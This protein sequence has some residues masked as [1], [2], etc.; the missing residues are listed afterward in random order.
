MPAGSRYERT[1]VGMRALYGTGRTAAR[2][3]PRWRRCLGGRRLAALAALAAIAVLGGCALDGGG[4]VGHERWNEGSAPR[5]QLRTAS[6]RPAESIPLPETPSLQDYLAYAALNNPGLEAAFE[7]WKAALERI[8]QVKALPD[9]RFTYRYYLRS[10]ETRD[11]PQEQGFGL[12]QAFPW[13]GKLKLKG[14]AAWEAAEAARMRYE[15]QRLRLFYRVKDAYY[16]YYYLGRAIAVVKEQRDFLKYLEEVLR[17]RYRA[18]AARHADVI[19]AQV[20]L[21]KL[22]DRH[23]TLMDLQEPMLARLNAALNRPADAQLPWPTEVVEPAL[24]ATDEEIMAWLQVASPELLE[25]QHE[26]AREEYG[27]QLARKDYYPDVTLGLDYV[28]TGSAVMET[29]DSGKDPVMAMVSL[30]LPIWSQ[31]RHAGV[32]EAESR[33]RAAAHMLQERANTLSAQVK[34]VLYRFRDAERKID[35]YRDTLLPKARQSVN[36]SETALRAATATFLDVMDAVRILLEFELSHQRALADSAQRAAELEMLVG[37]DLTR[38]AQEPQG[39][40]HAIEEPSG[41]QAP[42]AQ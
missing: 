17:A 40:E 27:V 26:I 19:R 41:A 16:E 18:A 4:R 24:S 36:A 13:F 20:E 38:G 1:A 8:P 22:D 9:P 28:Q 34:M 21:G 11:G 12:A 23:R 2:P 32:R 35:L 42:G 37:R 31:K 5:A 15:A 25:L 7:Q 14:D 29:P 3:G 10:V 30:N 6:P 39:E 33:K